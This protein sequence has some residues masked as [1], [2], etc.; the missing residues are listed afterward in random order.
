MLGYDFALT[1]LR[2][3]FLAVPPILGRQEKNVL[4]K[5]HN[6]EDL[7]CETYY[8]TRLSRPYC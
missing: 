5:L 3:I 4:I 8:E 1:T 7:E 6:L 2:L